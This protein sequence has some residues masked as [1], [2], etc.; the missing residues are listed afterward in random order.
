MPDRL[1]VPPLVFAF[2]AIVDIGT[3]VELGVSAGVRKRVI[4]ITGGTFAGPDIAGVVLDGGADWQSIRADGTADIL[5]RYTLRADDGTSISIVNPGFRHGPAAVIAQL[6]RGEDTD[7]ALYY[8][9]TT[10]RFEVADASVHA[11]LGRHAF[12]CTAARFATRVV[13]DYYRVG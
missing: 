7:P 8:F 2:R 5:A 4:P 10:P 9:R 1:P 3:P 11:W 13:L 6:A 12:V